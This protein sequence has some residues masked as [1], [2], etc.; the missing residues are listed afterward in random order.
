MNTCGKVS[1]SIFVI[2]LIALITVPSVFI[3]TRTPEGDLGRFKVAQKQ[4]GEKLGEW[5]ARI[6]T[7]KENVVKPAEEEKKVEVNAGTDA[8]NT[9]TNTNNTGSNTGTNANTN[10]NTTTNQGTN[11]NGQVQPTHQQQQQ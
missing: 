5:K 4:A 6:F 7:K 1:L 8:A 9:N 11:V 2:F 3:A 10:N